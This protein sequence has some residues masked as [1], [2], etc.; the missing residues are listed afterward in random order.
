MARIDHCAARPR[1]ISSR[2]ALCS[3]R[4]AR[5][6]GRGAYPPSRR[7]TP[8]TVP[9]P[10][11]KPSAMASSDKPLFHPCQS[12]ALSACVNARP[13]AIEHLLLCYSTRRCCN[14]GFTPHR[15]D[16]RKSR[17]RLDFSC[18]DQHDVSPP[19]KSSL[20]LLL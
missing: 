13:S 9:T 11:S 15:L 8:K 18:A 4:A 6:R 1:E 19:E 2:S 17:V 10:R 16:F 14:D 7:I 12:A 20:T 5:R 3:V